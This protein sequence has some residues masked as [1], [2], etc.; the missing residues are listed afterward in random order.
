[1]VRACS[2]LT[3]CPS[4]TNAPIQSSG[5]KKPLTQDEKK[6]KLLELFHE[7]RDVWALKDLEKVASKEKGIVLNTVKEILDM[8]VSDGFVN[9][10]KIGS[11]NYFFSFPGAAAATKK[12]QLQ[13]LETEVAT[14]KKTKVTLE[15][16]IEDATKGREATEERS[17][18]LAAL[19]E[20]ES[21]S[22]GL[23]T[24][25][26]QFKDCDPALIGAKEKAAKLAKAAANRWTDNIFCLQSHLSNKHNM[27]TADFCKFFNVPEDLDNLP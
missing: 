18:L 15:K 14:A 27:A 4:L 21:R 6:T 9:S 20:S 13:D 2:H 1:M 17:T 8:L 23:K 7:S 19:K 25:L 5:R 11:G 10:E 12:R 22:Q 26:L 16:D 3:L 24:E